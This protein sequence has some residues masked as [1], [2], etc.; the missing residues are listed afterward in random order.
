[1]ATERVRLSEEER[2]G[3]RVQIQRRYGQRCFYCNRH[4][5]PSRLRRRTFDHYIPYSLWR[6]WEP[7]N[8]VL[9]CVSCNLRKG[10]ALPWTVAFL[11][12][13]YARRDDYM[14]AA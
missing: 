1:M 3:L 11:L 14:E 6:A 4:F 2:A 5:K 8:L 13:Q 12:L 10:D 9:A 7:T